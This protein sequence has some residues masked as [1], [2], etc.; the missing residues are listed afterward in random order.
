MFRGADPY[1]FWLRNKDIGISSYS[2]PDRPRLFLGNERSIVAAIY[3]R[4]ATDVS[5][6]NIV[7]CRVDKENHRYLN[8]ISS[9]LNDC[10]TYSANVDQTGRA[11]IQDIV[12]SMF[13]EGVVAVVPTITDVSIE[14]DSFDIYSLRVGKITEW[15]PNYVRVLLYDE[16]TGTKKDV[17]VPKKTTA[18][19]ENPFYAVMNEPNSTLRRLIQ[20]LNLLDTIDNKSG[21]GKLDLLVQ[22][23]YGLRS[24]AKQN[25]AEMRRRQIESQLEDSRYGIAYIDA[26][27]HVTQ[28]NR[29]VENTLMTQIEYLTTTLYNQLGISE[30]VVKGTAD[31]NVMARYFSGTVEVILTAI[32]EEMSRKYLTQ[33]ARTQGQTIRFFRD[34]FKL[35]PVNTLAEMSDKLTRNEI[36]TSNEMRS[37]IGYKP[38]SNPRSDQLVNKNLKQKEEDVNTTQTSNKEE[39]EERNQNGSK[40]V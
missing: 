8:D 24:P 25:I 3:T 6:V 12:L 30:E 32:T 17:V 4:I 10:L 1:D 20:K 18:I 7:H 16:R 26:A 29:P 37:I 40:T 36:L 28:L 33:T 35:V 2:R 15:F 22:L 31:E 13:D 11:L 19:I 38:D 34:P 21:S 39:E 9:P 27:E 23:P 14:N 5:S